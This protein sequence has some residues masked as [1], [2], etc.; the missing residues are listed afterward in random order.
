[1]QAQQPQKT[2]RVSKNQRLAIDLLLILSEVYL[3][4]LYPDCHSWHLNRLMFVD[5]YR[6]VWKKKREAGCIDYLIACT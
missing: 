5:S 4:V 3:L 1:M 2:A 6:I